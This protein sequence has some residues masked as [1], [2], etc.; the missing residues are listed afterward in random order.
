MQIVVFMLDPI[1]ISK[2]IRALRAF[3][4]QIP[5]KDK[6]ERSKKVI[7]KIPFQKLSLIINWLQ[8]E[9]CK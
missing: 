8:I 5:S 3:R 7:S 4:G 9:K 1:L 6:N 2:K